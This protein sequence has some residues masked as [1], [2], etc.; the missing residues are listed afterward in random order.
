MSVADV[1]KDE[2]LSCF[3]DEC[4]FQVKY[5]LV[6]SAHSLMELPSRE[7]R[8]KLLLNLWQKTADFLVI[9]EQGTK[10]GFKAS[11]LPLSCFPQKSHIKM[12]TLKN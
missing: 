2:Y 1:Q 5:S 4:E 3:N 12:N 7:S 9:V 6:V 8:L 10:P 11:L